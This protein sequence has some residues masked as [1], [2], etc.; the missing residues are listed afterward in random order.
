MPQCTCLCATA[1]FCLCLMPAPVS[2]PRHI[3]TSHAIPIVCLPMSPFCEVPH[4]MPVMR[5]P[6]MSIM[7]PHRV[8]PQRVP[9]R[10]T[11]NVSYS[12]SNRSFSAAL[13]PASPAWV[14]SGE[15]ASGFSLCTLWCPCSMSHPSSFSMDLLSE[16]SHDRGRLGHLVS[17]YL[18][19]TVLEPMYHDTAQC[20]CFS[21]ALLQPLK[22]VRPKAN[23]RNGSPRG[24]CEQ[25]MSL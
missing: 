11:L 18:Q 25:N 13:D 3:W 14:P 22:Q 20:R 23:M 7:C 4:R 6:H 16:E 21:C 8:S 1:C 10:C 15:L 2:V 9:S 5:T 12:T 17:F 24:G 19:V